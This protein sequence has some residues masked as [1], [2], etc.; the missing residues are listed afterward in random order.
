MVC[1]AL[2]PPG[3]CRWRAG[4]HWRSARVHL[5]D[6]QIRVELQTFVGLSSGFWKTR[7]PGSTAVE[8]ST[9]LASSVGVEAEKE[10]RSWS[11]GAARVQSG[12]VS[13]LSARALWE[14]L[15]TMAP[16]VVASRS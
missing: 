4:C 16:L 2:S 1:S 9:G 10:K 14:V 7:E 8:G 6:R 5:S 13:G 3:C 11:D 12:T 15:D